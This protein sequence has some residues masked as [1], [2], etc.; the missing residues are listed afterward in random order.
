M[1]EDRG[2]RQREGGEK[3]NEK[4]DLAKR[5]AAAINLRF[6]AWAGGMETREA[7]FLRAAEDMLAA[8]DPAAVTA[9]V[10]VEVAEE[11]ADCCGV[12]SSTLVVFSKNPRIESN[13]RLNQSD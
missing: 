1:G 7:T 4:D 3:W 2:R 13:I 6:S 10:A 12:F 8:A 11:V 5:E 9:L